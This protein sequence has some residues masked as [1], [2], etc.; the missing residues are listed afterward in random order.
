VAIISDSLWRNTF[1]GDPSIIGRSITL[2]SDSFEVIGVMPREGSYP[3]WASVWLPLSQ[4][5][6]P[7]KEKAARIFHPLQVVGRLKAGVSMEAAQS[8]LQTIASRLQTVYPATNKT[9]SLQAVTLE[10]E[11]VGNV[12]PVL[13]LLLLVV[14]FVLL[15]ACI[16]VANLLLA[17]SLSRQKEFALRSALGASRGRLTSQVVVES[18]LLS[19]LGTGLGLSA[20]YLTLPAVRVWLGGM[21]PRSDGLRI[22]STVLMFTLF[23]AVVTGVAFGLA[24]SFSAWH[25]DIFG[26]LKTRDGGNQSPRTRILRNLLVVGEMSLA[27]VVLVTSGY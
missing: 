25:R 18:L 17:R 20:T 23:L 16:N 4:I 5:A 12:R 6:T 19:G 22:D 10:N 24:P 2:G 3:E 14:S 27:L 21:L 8:D 11:L 13:L 7:Y 26:L 1:G 15:I 9:I